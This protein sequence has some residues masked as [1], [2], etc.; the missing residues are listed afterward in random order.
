MSTT[1]TTTKKRSKKKSKSSIKI[2]ELKTIIIN[3][4]NIKNYLQK[5]SLDV[6]PKIWELPNRKSFNNWFYST[7]NKFKVGETLPK[8][9]GSFQLNR[10]QRL[11]KNF[12]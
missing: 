8:Q 3:D 10:I 7:F 9:K 12:F 5:F 6:N 1:T 4:N 11:I 2:K